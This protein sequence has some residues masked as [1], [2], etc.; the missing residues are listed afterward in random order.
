M[1]L[2]YKKCGYQY[3]DV[4]GKLFVHENTVRY[5]INKAQEIIT[6]KS[7]RDDFKETFSMALQIKC[8]LERNK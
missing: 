4:A 6:E 5:R 2:M 8:I 3:K 7:P 1:M